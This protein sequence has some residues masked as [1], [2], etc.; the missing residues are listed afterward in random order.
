MILIPEQV[1][2]LRKSISELECLQEEFYE[3]LSNRDC[4]RCITDSMAEHTLFQKMEQL[5]EY[6]ELLVHSEYVKEPQK[7]EIGIGTRFRVRFDNDMQSDEFVLIDSMIGCNMANS[8]VTANSPLGKSLIGKKEGES[9]S[10]FFE[11]NNIIT[12][13]IEK[14]QMDEKENPSFIRNTKFSARIA[15]S[16]EKEIREL[17]AKYLI[18]QDVNGDYSKRL[19]ITESQVELLGEEVERL[20]YQLGLSREDLQTKTLVNARIANIRNLLKSRIITAPEEESQISVGSTFSMMLF[21]KDRTIFKR[22][23]FINQAVGDELTDEYVERIT[24][25]GIVLYGLKEGDEFIYR[26]GSSYI[27][28]KVYD[29]QNKKDEPRIMNAVAYQRSKKMYQTK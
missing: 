19:A 20:S 7:D 9:F 28:G 3:Y 8:S 12:G 26:R 5:R 1:S 10:C 14:I 2:F 16:T 22:V 29:I 18:G 25:L 15:E 21:E 6:R 23:E 27:S 13:T 4:A 17:K 24:P 11:S